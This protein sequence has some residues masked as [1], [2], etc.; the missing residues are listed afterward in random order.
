MKNTES[1]IE[2]LT[3]MRDRISKQE[4]PICGIVLKDEFKIIA[5]EYIAKETI[6]ICKVHPTPNIDS[7]QS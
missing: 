4:C 5:D 3:L 1:G 2:V 6:K 7:E